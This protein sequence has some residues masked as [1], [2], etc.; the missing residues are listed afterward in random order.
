MSNDILV[1]GHGSNSPLGQIQLKETVQLL[2]KRLPDRR[3]TFGF[4]E[5]AKPDVE[6]A[7]AEFIDESTKGLTV[8][9]LVLLG[10]THAKSDIAGIV[11]M[12]REIYRNV[13]FCYARELGVS[14]RLNQA[15]VES[16]SKQ[17][18]N[19]TV[20]NISVL[21]VGR[22]SSDP[23]AN[24]DLFKAGRLMS[25]IYKVE[26]VESCFIS[27]ASPSVANALDRLAR[28]EPHRILIV[29]YFL[30]AGVLVDRISEQALAWSANN[31]TFDL[32]IAG[33]LG[34]NAAIVEVSIERIL[35]AEGNEIRMSCDRCVYRA[36]TH[37][38]EHVHEQPLNVAF[39]KHHH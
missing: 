34:P 30:F 27:L 25:E 7:L 39:P 4:L 35:E 19:S 12:A 15:F 16:A 31:P 33:E 17:L 38:F 2:A 13:E 28:H 23:D 14:L 5:L 21:L 8:M 10:A 29:P 9:P 24:S 11:E 22:G 1:V 18:P 37:G 6:D 26:N 20:N 32:Q 36:R 3:V